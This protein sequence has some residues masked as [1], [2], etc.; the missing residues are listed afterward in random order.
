MAMAAGLF[1]QVP[2][3]SRHSLP[4]IVDAN[5]EPGNWLTYSRTYDG[6]R[7]S[8]LAGITRANV[9]GLKSLW[10]YQIP[11]MDHFETTPSAVDGVLYITEPPMQVRRWTHAQAANC[12][13]IVRPVRRTFNACC[14]RVNRGVAILDKT[15][16]VGTLDAHLIALN[17]SNGAWC[18]TRSSP[19]T[20]LATR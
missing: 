5:K 4:A 7:Y 20:R 6:H 19:I 1:A 18:G 15:L 8:P 12:G 13:V 2:E 16:F 11:Q 10:T 14:G 17:A 3:C 9:A